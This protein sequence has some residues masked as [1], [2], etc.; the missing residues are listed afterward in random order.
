MRGAPYTRDDGRYMNY[1][2]NQAGS[3]LP[4]FV[5]SATQ[6][7]G[8]IGGIFRSLYRMAMP[9]IRRGF[10]IATPHIKTA[11]KAAAKNIAGDIVTSMVT[12][13]TAPKQEGS[14]LIVKHRRPLKRPP[15]T[16][17][18]RDLSTKRRRTNK[19]GSSARTQSKAKHRRTA[20]SKIFSRDIF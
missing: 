20:Q 19:C 5:G 1:Y 6:Y 4:G 15:R 11:A 8:G 2:T 16:A 7:G 10:N 17:Q 18:G 3:G 13:A 9:L 12:R 14:G